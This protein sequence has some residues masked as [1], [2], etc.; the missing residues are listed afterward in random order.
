MTKRD[1]NAGSPLPQTKLPLEPSHPL[2]TLLN[3]FD[4]RLHE[5]LASYR[6]YDCAVQQ[7]TDPNQLDTSEDWHFGLFLYQ[8]H[9]TQ[10]GECLKQQW[11]DVKQRLCNV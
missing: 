7:L 4:D 1:D 3:Q 9:L 6:F 2:T 10:R 11:I 5:L 8:Q